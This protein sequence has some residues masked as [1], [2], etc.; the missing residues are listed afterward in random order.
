[1]R[2]LLVHNPAAGGGRSGRLL[3]P[4]LERLRAGGLEVSQHRTVSLGDACLAAREAAGSV[5]VV[6]AM[7]GDGTVGAC[8]AGL[9]EAG[10][11]VTGNSL[12]AGADVTTGRDQGRLA[13]LGIVPAGGGNDGARN[14]GL[15]F[16]D[17]LAAATLLPGLTARPAD[18]VRAGERYLL[19]AG[20]AG[21][22]AE[23]SRRANQGLSKAPQRLRYIGAVLAELATGRPRSFRLDLDGQQ[24]ATSAWLVAVANSQSFGGGMRIAP[25]A[26]LDD[27]LLDLVII[28]GELSKRGFLATFPKVFSGRHV[29]HPAVRVHRAARVTL[30]ADGPVAV[31]LDG[32]PA[33]TVPVSFEVAPGALAVFAAGDAPAFS[34]R[35]S[36]A[37]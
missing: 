22:D 24:I 18:L 26:L 19:N 28:G 34:R 20:G 10:L 29:E 8:A 35:P 1:M 5:D 23:V 37:P 13:A 16:G 17:P 21:F 6:V 2:A 36:S 11:A 7:G 4:V 3:R 25:G 33:G 31:H 14:L 27:G 15:P 30:E 32:E 12:A 9:A